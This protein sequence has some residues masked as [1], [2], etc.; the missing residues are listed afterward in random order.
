MRVGDTIVIDGDISLFLPIDGE[1]GIVTKVVGQDLPTYTDATEVTPSGNEQVL[2]TA[3]MV[4]TKNII[5]NPIP[6]NYGRLLWS[7]NTLTVY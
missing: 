6:E 1:S 4:L 2:L 7:G 3:D 5:V